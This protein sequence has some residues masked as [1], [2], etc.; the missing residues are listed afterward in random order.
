LGTP[1]RGKIGEVAQITHAGDVG[2]GKIKCGEDHVD[3]SSFAVY[4]I[5]I[6]QKKCDVNRIIL[7][8]I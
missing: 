7:Q 1:V 5:S 2:I 8:K 3:N 6:S 4:N